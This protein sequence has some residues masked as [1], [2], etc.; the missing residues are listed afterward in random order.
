MSIDRLQENIRKTKCPVVLDF[1]IMKINNE[2]FEKTGK[3]FLKE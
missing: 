3:A 1:D 2:I